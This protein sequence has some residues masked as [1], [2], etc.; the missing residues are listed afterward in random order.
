MKHFH[1]LSVDAPCPR[2]GLQW[3]PDTSDST[4][5]S[6]T[7]QR[8]LGTLCSW[9]QCVM[10]TPGELGLV[11]RAETLHHRQPR[12]RGHQGGARE[13]CPTSSRQSVSA[14]RHPCLLSSCGQTRARRL[15]WCLLSGHW[16]PVSV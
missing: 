3:P 15:S 14:S 7:E 13:P 11:T 5:A 4:F 8:A 2:L 9:C 10:F 16:G 6:V 1:V 12:D